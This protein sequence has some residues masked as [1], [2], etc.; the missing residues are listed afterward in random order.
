M[1]KTGLSVETLGLLQNVFRKHLNVEQVKLYG[2]RAK[3][4]YNERSDIDLAAYGK[5]L[6]RFM[7]A[8]VLLDLDDLDIPY[9][10]ELQNFQDLKN[11]RLIE[12]IGRVGVVI[13]DRK[14]EADTDL[15]T[16]KNGE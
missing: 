8:D 11:R 7:I 3:G 5:A 12:H 4:T 14:T 13:F 10:I 15:N 2:S 16:V 6:N 9:L 1:Q